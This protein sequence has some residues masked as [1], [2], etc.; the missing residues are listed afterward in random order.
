VSISNGTAGA[1]TAPARTIN[2]DAA[3]SAR[4]ELQ[5]EPVT[6][7]FREVTF[8]LPVEMPA[9]FALHAQAERLRESVAALI[10]EKA[11]EFF[12]LR[13]SIEDITELVNAAA[14]IYGVSPG[15]AAASA[16][17]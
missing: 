14:R 7:I 3:A 17:S 12:T 11:E 13:P 1:A 4:A 5:G 8:T 10:G 16:G 15:E 6:L 9:D 2:L